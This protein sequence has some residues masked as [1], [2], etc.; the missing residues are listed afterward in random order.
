MASTDPNML[1]GKPII[2]FFPNF[3]YI[4][5]KSC[6]SQFLCVFYAKVSKPMMQ[7]NRRLFASNS[8]S[9]CLT[10]A[11]WVIADDRGFNW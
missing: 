6:T 7:T 10:S 2:K 5:E 11:I 8:C 9:N 4:S 3:Q 1:V